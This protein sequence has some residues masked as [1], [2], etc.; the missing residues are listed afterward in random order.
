MWVHE[1]FTTYSESLF[2]DYHYGKEAGAEYVR[3]SRVGIQNRKP[4]IGPY[5]VNGRGGDLYSKGS[6]VL[7][8]LRTWLDDDEKWRNILRGLNKEFYHA[9]VTTADV[10]NYIA[11][12]SGLELTAFFD[13]YLRTAD[14][15]V[16]EYFEYEGKLMYRWTNC[17][18]EFDM[19]VRVMVDGEEQ[20]INP[21]AGWN[22]RNAEIEV[23]DINTVSID[24][25]YYIYPVSITGNE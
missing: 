11:E 9:T 6:N 22:F 13:Q 16:L 12:Q 5:G 15:P 17:I 14:I 21:T 8:T 25:N 20:I 7:H 1:S 4:M 10:E 19:P 2:I 18:A 3:G 24:P 23:K